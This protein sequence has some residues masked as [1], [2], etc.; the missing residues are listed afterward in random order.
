MSDFY[1]RNSFND[2]LQTGLLSAN[3]SMQWQQLRAINAYASAEASAREL[4]RWE[5]IVR[6]RWPSIEDPMDIEEAAMR[7][8]DFDQME[9]DAQRNRDMGL[10]LPRQRPLS[11]TVMGILAL[12][13]GMGLGA[14]FID[15]ESSV[16][17]S[18]S[19][20]V[21]AVLM[22]LLSLWGVWFLSGA[23]VPQ[24]PKY[25]PQDDSLIC[26]TVYPGRELR[27]ISGRKITV[28]SRR[29]PRYE[30]GRLTFLVPATDGLMYSS[31]DIL[32]DDEATRDINRSIG[33]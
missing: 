33:R 32:W 26:R 9:T 22:V 17:D 30:P 2:Y 21:V 7:L 23:F 1:P 11:Q 13:F 27:T 19:L 20:P 6:H 24:R 8:M 29:T 18:S 5:R 10:H 25:H 3:L 28:D 14:W 12:L 31:D 16:P 4:Q 15:A